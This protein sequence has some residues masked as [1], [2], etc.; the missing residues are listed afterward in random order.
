MAVNHPYQDASLSVEDRVKVLLGRMTLEEKVA[1]LGGVWCN[2]LYPG[3][4]FSRAKA[5]ELL[6]NGI[7]QLTRPIGEKDMKPRRAAAIIKEVQEYIARHTRL[8]IPAMVH[9]ECLTGFM[10][11][12]MTT[13][14]Q[15]IGLA[16]TF[17]PEI[18]QG[19][20]DVIRGHFRTLGAVQ[21]LS[22]VLDVI[23]DPRWGRTE[24]TFGED[25]VLVAAM[26]TAYVKGLQGDDPKTGV[27]ATI[28]HFAAHGAPE[29]G[30]NIASVHCGPREY[31][32]V[33]LFPFEAAVKR[34][35]AR[36]LMNAYHDFRYVTADGFADFEDVAV[37][38]E[39]D[40]LLASLEPDQRARAAAFL[41]GGLFAQLLAQRNTIVI[42][43]QSIFVHGGVLPEHL[44]RG[45]D[46]M[47]EEI[48]A[49]LRAEAPQPEWI[50]GDRSPVWT[51][52]FSR[53]PD[54]AACDTLSLVL[55][56]LGVERMVVGHTVQRTG[57]TSFCGGR[58]W[59]ID[60]GMA[61]YYGGRPAV[62]EIR[63]DGV[64]GL[65]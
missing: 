8:K 24:E 61:A 64:R 4:K 5:K 42:V 53:E 39:A 65:R 58:V 55:D 51:R 27:D 18:V 48:R 36:S 45:L 23:R 40:S 28:K 16:S 31:R 1:Q 9:E 20:T 63:K 30:R 11:R 49:W 60:V 12:K 41:P 21:G 32:E 46:S 35:K 14:P 44:D 52:L 59:C 7:G 6:A 38:D 25:H 56:R 50:R 37:V 62:L 13:Y 34:G 29:G 2:K 19:M 54:V 17:Q 10:A 43:G 33:F 57:V 15:A 47:N 22:P 3:D 26:A